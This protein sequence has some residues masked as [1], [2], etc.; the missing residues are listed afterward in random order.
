MYV[1]N[2]LN[3]ERVVTVLLENPR[4][5]DTLEQEIRSPLDMP[6]SDDARP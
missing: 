2:I 5:L 1:R 6:D 3:S 4:V